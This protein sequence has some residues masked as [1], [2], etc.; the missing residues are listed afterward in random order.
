MG[1][2]AFEIRRYLSVVSLD[3]IMS[4][5]RMKIA[6]F[7]G[8]DGRAAAYADERPEKNDSCLALT[9]FECANP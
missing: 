1:L 8:V 3:K 7:L 5:F 2:S 9:E 6:S 4:R